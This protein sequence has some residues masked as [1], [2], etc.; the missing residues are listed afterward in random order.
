VVWRGTVDICAVENMLTLAWGL[1]YT[2]RLRKL[3]LFKQIRTRETWG[4]E[5]LNP[6]PS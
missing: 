5:L 1:G 3:N 4:H 2:L 6:T